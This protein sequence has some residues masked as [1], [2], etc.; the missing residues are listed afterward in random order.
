MMHIL[1]IQVLLNTNSGSMKYIELPLVLSRGE[2]RSLQL[3]FWDKVIEHLFGIGYVLYSTL[4]HKRA[5]TN[6]RILRKKP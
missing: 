6:Y 5:G 4:S 2:L 1:G 3:R